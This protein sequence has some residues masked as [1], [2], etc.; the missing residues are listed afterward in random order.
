M[1]VF[2]R[3]IDPF[4]FP[5]FYPFWMGSSSQESF[6]SALGDTEPVWVETG[7]IGQGG[8]GKVTLWKNTVSDCWELVIAV[9]WV[10]STSNLY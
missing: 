7:T 9:E 8:F 4:I 6:S 5:P 10:H 3:R 2:A 1:A